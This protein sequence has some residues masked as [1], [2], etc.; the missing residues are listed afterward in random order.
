MVKIL[1]IGYNLVGTPRSTI[2]DTYANILDNFTSM[3]HPLSYRAQK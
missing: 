3:C 2:L 1:L